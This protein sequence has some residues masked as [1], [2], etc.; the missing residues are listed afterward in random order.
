MI[1]LA[2]G[3]EK[4]FVYR[5]KGSTPSMHAGAG[6]LRNDLSLRPQ[7]FTL[8]TM[9]RQLQGFTGRALRLPSADPGTWLLLWQ[10]GERRRLTAWTTD[11]TTTLGEEFGPA[12]A[13]D[14]CGREQRLT[15]TAQATIGYQ[16][17]YFTIADSPA[18]QRLV[19]AG[20]ARD[21][22][23]RAERERKATTPLAL[24]DFGSAARVGMLHGFG[25]PRRFT[26]VGKDRLWDAASGFGFLTAAAGED[27]Q[28]WVRDALEGD[29]VR[30]A[31]ETVFRFALPAGR[32][33]LRI[34]A[35]TMEGKGVELRITGTG[36]PVSATTAD[37]DGHVELTVTAGSEPLELSL[38]AWGRLRWLSSEP[39]P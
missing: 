26:P 16:P 25:P 21:S 37:A 35:T 4:V 27:D 32:H 30:C 12:V 1:A 13:V 39:L 8:A 7:W 14:A 38:A 6:L 9:M 22:Q 18:L 36:A 5:E 10:D 29:S 3:V 20:R 23:V 34:S 33:R 15:T 31:P 17:T 2:A 28:E 19:A 24:F 11:K